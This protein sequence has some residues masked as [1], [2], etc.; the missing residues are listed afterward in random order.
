MRKISACVAALA[1]CCALAAS[2]NAGQATID[3]KGNVLM[4]DAQ[5]NTPATSSSRTAQGAVLEMHH[6]YGNF[7]GNPTPDEASNIN[8]K[9]PKGTIV[10]ST[11]FARCPIPTAETLGVESRCP[12]ASKMGT[13][14][15]SVDA[16]RSGLADQLSGTVN[17]YNGAARN[18]VPTLQLIAT[19]PVPGSAT[20]IT[21]E[22]D[23]EI[24]K[25]P[26]LVEYDTVAPTTNNASFDI[27]AFD[28]LV[29]KTVNGVVKGKKAKISY[30][31]TPKTCTKKG[32]A[33]ELGLT[34]ATQPS[35]IAKDTAPCLKVTG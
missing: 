10:N 22:I 25:G 1:L 30:F 21:A 6:F 20:P 18:G 33:F 5:F 19:I 13:G 31:V 9:F 3:D 35:A 29:G 11:L 12:P 34:R 7:R 17:V 28:L 26:E 14:T 15:A 23:F 24:R 2:A 4:L 32:W 16:R 27:T 8:F